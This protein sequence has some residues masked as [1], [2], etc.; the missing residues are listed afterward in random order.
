MRWAKRRPEAAARLEAARSAL[1]ELSQRIG[2]P[3]ENLVSPELVRRLCWDWKDAG[4][5]DGR[6]I[7]AA[8]E[9]ILR[10]GGARDWQR[11]LVGPELTRALSPGME[12]SQ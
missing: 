8:I 7:A 1:A 4:D 6:D 3:T 5:P 9:D 12:L 2:I 10:D 11:A